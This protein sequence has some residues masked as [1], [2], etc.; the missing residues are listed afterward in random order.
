M[1]DFNRRLYEVVKRLSAFDR[2]KRNTKTTTTRLHFKASSPPPPATTLPPP[3]PT[4]TIAEQQTASNESSQSRVISDEQQL[5]GDV[6]VLFSQS[7]ET[8]H[9][10]ASRY[11]QEKSSTSTT[12]EHHHYHQQQNQSSHSYDASIAQFQAEI[13]DDWKRHTNNWQKDVTT[14]IELTT[15]LR[16]GSLSEITKNNNN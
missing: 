15:L 13:S 16:H 9:Q 10:I 11:M 12:E 2:Y 8:C 5:F 7:A 4:S 3:S 6:E 14:N 1:N